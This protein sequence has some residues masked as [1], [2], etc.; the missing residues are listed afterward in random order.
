V[1]I[2]QKAKQSGKYIDELAVFHDELKGQKIILP[3]FL[4][5]LYFSINFATVND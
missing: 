1:Q 2:G 3:D 5:S 4:Q